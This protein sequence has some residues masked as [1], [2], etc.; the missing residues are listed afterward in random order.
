M[1]TRK[2]KT[3]FRNTV[4]VNIRGESDLSSRRVKT[5]IQRSLEELNKAFESFKNQN[6]TDILKRELASD[7]FRI[8]TLINMNML[9]LAGALLY[10]HENKIRDASE[11]TPDLF[12]DQKLNPF[13]TH[14]MSDFLSS[15]PDEEEIRDMERRYKETFFRYIIKVLASRDQEPQILDI[16]AEEPEEGAYNQ[17]NYES[18]DEA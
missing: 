17:N 15:S 9:V 5:P 11:F 10:L 14:L 6:V 16:Q 18:E 3:A 13:L 4:E 8:D 2:T 12:S 1:A 7:A